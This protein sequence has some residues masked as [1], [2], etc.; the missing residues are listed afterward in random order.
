[1][2]LLSVKL[3]FPLMLTQWSALLNPLLKSPVAAPN[4]LKNIS[5]ASGSNTIN[6][7]LG[8]T[9]QGYQV[10]MNSAAVTFYDSQNTNPTPD[11]TLVLVASGATTVSLL[12]F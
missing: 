2:G 7:T 9:L 4:L 12:V 5:L 1:M 6:H 11:K 3:P 8:T 10:V